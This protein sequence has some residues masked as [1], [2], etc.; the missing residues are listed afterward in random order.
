M[1][2]FVDAGPA[3]SA[4]GEVAVWS[5]DLD[6]WGECGQGV[7]EAA[8]LANLA[9][10]TGNIQQRIV[11]RITTARLEQVFTA[12]LLPATDEQIAATSEALRHERALTTALISRAS[13]QQLDAVD[14]DV[15]QPSWMRWRTAAAVAWHIADTESRHYMRLLGA[16]ERAA[17]PDLLVEL[18]QSGAW[19]QDRLRTIPRSAVMQHRTE[20]W[21]TVKVLRRLAWHERV[22]SVFL[23]R[24]LQAAGMDVR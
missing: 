5:F 12:D 7:D 13:A 8:A 20:T 21:T 22:E 2:V 23:R 9:R 16:G 4:L 1:D 14:D 17:V 6:H 15:A 10:R 11:D 18:E 19:I 24:R 3:M